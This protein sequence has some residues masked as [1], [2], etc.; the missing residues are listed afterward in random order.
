M[1]F[2]DKIARAIDRIISASIGKQLLFFLLIVAV[3]FVIALTLSSLFFP[4]S[5]LE[6]PEYPRFWNMVFNFINQG[7]F[8]DM[9]TV[10]R[11]FMLL[12]N[13]CGMILFAGV[14]VALLT[15]TIF[16][17]IENVQNGEVYYN[18]RRHIVIFGYDSICN[19]LVKQLAKNNEIVLQTS[20]NVQ[21][22]R[23]RLFSGLGEELKKKVTI[24]SGSRV[25]TE[26]V[27]KLN[28]EKCTEIFLLGELNEDDHDSKNIECLGIISAL[29][30]KTG[31]HIRCHVLFKHHMTFSAFQQNEIPGIR[32][33]IDLVPFNF[34]DMWAQKIFVDNSFNDGEIT[35]KPL[36][37]EPVTEDS[38]KRVHLV[39]FGM[40]NMGIALGLQAA[41]LCHFPNYITK[42]IKT[43]ITFI[44]ADAERETNKLKNRLQAFFEEVDYMYIDTDN[45]ALNKSPDKKNYFTDVEF[46]FIKEHFEDDTIDEYLIKIAADKNSILTIAVALP[47]SAQALST[48]L[49]FPSAVYDCGASILVRQENSRAIVSMLSQEVKGNTYRKY[50]NLRPFGMLENSY[51][52]K[53]ADNLLPMMVKY[54][55]DNTKFDKAESIKEFPE[56]I[57]RENWMKNW[58]ESDNIA[59]HKESNRYMANYI[60]VMKRSLGIKEGTDLNPRQ[61]NLAA[62]MVHN[63]WV[64]EKLLVGFRAPT[65]EEAALINKDNRE[66]YKARF[67]HEDI[68]GYQELGKDDMEIDVKVYDINIANAIPYMLLHKAV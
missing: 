7:G 20:K 52:L 22:I 3:V 31:K 43:L 33:V 68:K 4:S 39:I 8:E 36:D 53:Q 23:Q 50:R 67:I 51:D 11:I 34:Y 59:V 61:I 30:A 2:F 6:R 26:D 44:D 63:H 35:Y 21:E 12:T 54:A 13:I 16:Q 32:G 41:Q 29:C 14:L 9:G 15:N 17:R 65:P 45:K 48:A 40:S 57:I 56:N 49:Y 62:R 1:K 27:E 37:W 55:Y 42:G 58:R 64:M 66:E 10:E 60:S 24:V 19:G 25:S 38:D 46:E 18:F 47:D 28:I 5:V